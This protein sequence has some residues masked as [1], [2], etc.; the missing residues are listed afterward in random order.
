M[1]PRIRGLPSPTT[2]NPCAIPAAMAIT[3]VAD[4]GTLV[5]APFP[6]A[7]IVPPELRPRLKLVPAAIAT[8]LLAEAGM[9]GWSE[10]YPQVNGAPPGLSPRLWIA[11]AE[12]AAM[13]VTV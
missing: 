1:P 5:T 11:P 9:L 10:V 13:S 2:A 4:C 8:R 7:R 3:L 6:Q 12:M